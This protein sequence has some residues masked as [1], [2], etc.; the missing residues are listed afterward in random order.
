MGGFFVSL[1]GLDLTKAASSARHHSDYSPGGCNVNVVAK[2]GEHL[3]IRTFERGVEAETLSCGT[4]VVAAALADMAREDASA[5]RH[6]RHVI[7]RGGRL[8]VEATR[9]VEGTFQDVWLFGAARRVFRGTWAWALAFLALWSD[10]AMAGDLADQ[11][12]ESARVSVL[13]AS[14]G[15]DLYAAFGHTAIR[16]FDP[17]VRLD[18]VFNYGTFVVDEGFTCAL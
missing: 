5:G 8:E 2:E 10:P 1:D 11:L 3:Y 15:A 14:P 17:S 18:Y 7:A 16:V 6:V 9:Q 12:T 4:G 13:T